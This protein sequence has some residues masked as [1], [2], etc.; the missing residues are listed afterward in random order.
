MCF[1]DSQL[2][3]SEHIHQKINKAYSI[4]YAWNN[5][6]EFHTYGPQNIY[7]VIQVECDRLT[8]VAMKQTLG[9]QVGQEMMTPR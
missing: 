3:F 7:Y 2:T 8:A 9:R 4:E 1:F 6:E 5:K